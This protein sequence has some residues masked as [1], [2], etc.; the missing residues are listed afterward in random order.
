MF[1]FTIDGLEVTTIEGENGLRAIIAYDEGTESPRTAWD[2]VGTM[3]CWHTRYDLGDI[4]A[5]S[6]EEAKK[7]GRRA[8]RAVQNG[9]LAVELFLYDHSGI[10]MRAGRGFGDIDSAGWDWG[11]VGVIY[12][13]KT[14]IAKEFGGDLDKARAALYAEV[15][16][17]D[18]YLTG[19]VYNITIE[20]A[21][22]NMVDGYGGVY[23]Y[24][25]AIQE[26][27]V[28]LDG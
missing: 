16:E 27:R 10:T 5:R 8:L 3:L 22:G 13:T 11:Q 9:G 28:M 2:N 17:Y 25:N 24:D 7:L 18:Q 14:K 21:E 12:I 1:D 19:D 6:E 20:D 26:A 23:G 4:T 15:A